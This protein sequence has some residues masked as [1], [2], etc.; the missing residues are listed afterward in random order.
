[1]VKKPWI[2][3]ACKSTVMARSTPAASSRSATRRAL[4]AWREMRAATAPG[5]REMMITKT[6]AASGPGYEGTRV[7][8][9]KL[10]T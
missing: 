10:L 8:E 5:L 2:C 1:L 9:I 7:Q 6:M 3:D 4:R